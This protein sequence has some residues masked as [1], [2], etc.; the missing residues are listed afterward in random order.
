MARVLR[1]AEQ[2]GPDRNEPQRRIESTVPGSVPTSHARN[3][4]RDRWF[5]LQAR[6]PEPRKD[7]SLSSVHPIPTVPA[8]VP[9]DGPRKDPE[10]LRPGEIVRSG[11]IQ[12]RSGTVPRASPSVR[13]RKGPEPANKKRPGAGTVPLQVPRNRPIGPRRRR[14][15][16]GPHGSVLSDPLGD[17]HC[18]GLIPLRVNLGHVGPSMAQDHLGPFHAE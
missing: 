17:L 16:T 18:E 14:A 9:D 7:P 3:T 4:Q 10:T 13:V 15:R 12:T 8:P 5:P 11:Y 1:N 2:G 6:P